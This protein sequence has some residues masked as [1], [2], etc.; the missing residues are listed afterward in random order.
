[1]TGKSF[2][3]RLGF[4][5]D[6]LLE[7]LGPLPQAYQSLLGQLADSGWIC[8]GTGVCR[9]LRRKV[10]GQWV[11]KGPYYLWTGKRQGKTVCHALSKSQYEAAQQAIAANRRVLQILATLQGKTLAQIIKKVPGVRKRK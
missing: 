5:Q 9:P 6:H 3:A 4:M 7:V 11:D 1:L 8:Q 2:A 10:K